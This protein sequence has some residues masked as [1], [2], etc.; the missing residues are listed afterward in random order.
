MSQS[1]TPA[2]LL[3]HALNC[4]GAGNLREA[5]LTYQRV[6]DHDPDQI[7]ALHYLGV[8]GLQTGR[9]DIAVEHIGKAVALRPGNVDALINLGNA[10]QGLD[11][12]DQAIQ[13]FK[14]AL[15]LQSNSAVALA[16]IGNALT[17]QG[18]RVDAIQYLERALTINPSLTEARRN[19]ADA[20][21]EEGSVDEALLQIK[22]AAGADP[23][24]ISIKASLAS[25]LAA[26]GEHETAIAIYESV[27]A[28][29][30]DFPPVLCNLAIIY[31]EVGRT[32]EAIEV[33]EKV[34]RL[35]PDYA[36]GQ[37]QLGVVLRNEGDKRR[38]EV[39]FRSAISS[40]PYCTKAWR[41]IASLDAC[42][43]DSEIL[44]NLDDVR[45]LP[46]LTP[47]QQVHLDFAAGKCYEDIGE[48]DDAAQYI[49]TAN[50]LHRKS[51]KY[52]VED[53]LMVFANIKRSF[54]RES[55]PEWQDAGV[56]DDTAIFVIG[57]PRSGTSLVEQ[58][59]ASHSKVHGG[60]ELRYLGEA[61]RS[62]IDLRAGIDCTQSLATV[63][64]ADIE[65]VAKHYLSNLRALDSDAS[66]VTDKLPNNFLHIGLIKAAMPNARIVHCQR[67]S[68]DTCW[69]IYKNYF[70]GRGHYY[71]YEQAELA[72][73][74]S[75]YE[76]LMAHWQYVFPDEI[77]EVRYEELVQ[78]QE[79]VTRALLDACQLPFEASCLDFHK[80][81]RSVR[82]NSANQVRRPVYNRSVGSWKNVAASIEPLLSGLH[83]SKTS[84][85]ADFDPDR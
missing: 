60:G 27:L 13:I 39:A 14:Q 11:Q 2:E 65:Q 79:R 6:L 66:H 64:S 82:T 9:F 23:D 28:V 35:D 36:E 57:M 49:S 58:I 70:T 72:A 16:N 37:Y 63:S 10:H 71:A 73:Y 5:A 80:T 78:D 4:H 54:S 47:E 15:D 83:Q 24:S 46:D 17:H 29:Q 51:F 50:Q 21:L 53:D 59:L 12:L 18:R 30:A 74:Y 42:S 31:H 40:D 56:S 77:V 62:R 69:S 7:D 38:A 81:A 25:I 20:L 1:K 67:D 41:D 75:A 61:I 85:T 48:F 19:L 76:D 3:Q 34:T 45:K 33:L 55:F 44:R 43:M 68:R 26:R 84:V 22:E 8:I 32:R 52:D